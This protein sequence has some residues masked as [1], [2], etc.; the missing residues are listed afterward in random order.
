MLKNAELHKNNS[1]LITMDLKD[2]FP[3]VGTKRVYANIHA[4]IGKILD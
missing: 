3:S 1:Y 2:A 4:A